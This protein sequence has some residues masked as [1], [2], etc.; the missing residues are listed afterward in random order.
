VEGNFVYRNTEG[1]IQDNWKVNS[2]LT[3][4]Y[5]LRFVQQAPQYDRLGQASNFLPERWDASA[6]PA[7]YP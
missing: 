7:L 5:G 6:A 1:Y 2:R 4:D 3:L